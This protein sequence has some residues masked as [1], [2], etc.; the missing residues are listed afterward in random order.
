MPGAWIRSSVAWLS[1][2]HVATPT[3]VWIKIGPW[4]TCRPIAWPTWSQWKASSSWFSRMETR[5]RR[6]TRRATARICWISSITRSMP[7]GRESNSQSHDDRREPISASLSTRRCRS[8]HGA[9]PVQR[10]R[11]DRAAVPIA[12]GLDVGPVLRVFLPDHRRIA[13]LEHELDGAVVEH[14]GIAAYLVA[15]VGEEPVLERR[16]GGPGR[17]QDDRGDGRVPLGHRRA[18]CRQEGQRQHAH[19]AGL[20][21]HERSPGLSHF[22]SSS[23]RKAPTEAGDRPV[24]PDCPPP[25]FSSRRGGSG[26]PSKPNRGASPWSRCESAT[27]TQRVDRPASDGSSGRSGKR[28]SLVGTSGASARADC[29]AADLDDGVSDGSRTTTSRST[30]RGAGRTARSQDSPARARARTAAAAGQA[31]WRQGVPRR[32]QG[33]GLEHQPVPIE[34][35]GDRGRAPQCGL[36]FL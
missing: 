21:N 27:V 18:R 31:R 4:L 19:Q 32:R 26:G 35:A 20:A 1:T 2:E 16:D 6:K 24:E 33:A 22:S 7:S 30:T 5:A 8:S 10:D 28:P 34:P 25:P 12:H 14:G 13:D 11:R 15:A 29:G 3:R 9:G 23:R 17:M 36:D